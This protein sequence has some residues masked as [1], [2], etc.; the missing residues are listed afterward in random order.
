MIIAGHV[1]VSAYGFWLPNDQRESWSDFVRRWE[2][3]RFG[4]ATKVTTRRSLAREPFDPAL[5]AAAK[6]ALM[7]PAVHFDG[8][9]ALA[10]AH[11]FQRAIQRTG[12]VVHACAILPEHTHIVFAR[13]TYP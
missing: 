12:C 9:Q 4:P 5:R 11:G 8:R 3:L 1:I 10:I 6:R 13:H 2:L 7:Y